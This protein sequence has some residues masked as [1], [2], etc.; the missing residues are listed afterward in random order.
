MEEKDLENL[1]STLTLSEPTHGEIKVNFKFK[2]GEHVES[3]AKHIQKILESAEMDKEITQLLLSKIQLLFNNR[4][5]ALFDLLSQVKT[6]NSMRSYSYVVSCSDNVSN[7]FFDALKSLKFFVPKE[8]G[9]RRTVTDTPLS[10][11]R[12]IV[13]DDTRIDSIESGAFIGSNL[14]YLSA[15][16]THIFQVNALNKLNCEN[17]ESFHFDNTFISHPSNCSLS[18]LK[19]HDI[20]KFRLQTE[21]LDRGGWYYRK[22]FQNYFFPEMIKFEGTLSNLDDRPNYRKLLAISQFQ[23]VGIDIKDEFFKML[24]KNEQAAKKEQESTN[25]TEKSQE[26]GRIN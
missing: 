5:V 16:N 9:Y 3:F 13:L 2:S 6:Y 19:T 20:I 15:K 25:K 11:L 22:H 10:Y 14:R 21:G 17:L 18:R 8:L 4:N 24:C 23:N 12:S 7:P 1:F 26:R